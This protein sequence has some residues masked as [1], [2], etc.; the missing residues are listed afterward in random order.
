[1]EQGIVNILGSGS[2]TATICALFYFVLQNKFKQD[3]VL[4]E[5]NA[6]RDEEIRNSIDKLCDKID[7]LVESNQKL[8]ADN[9]ASSKESSLAYTESKEHYANIA[10]KIDA[11]DGKVDET[12]VIAT[13]IFDKLNSGIKL[14]ELMVRK[15]VITQSQLDEALEEQRKFGSM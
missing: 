4:A 6:R 7:L 1:M 12:I 14:G 15:G 2:T 5:S 3:T 10:H 8:S 13:R 9:A 11:V